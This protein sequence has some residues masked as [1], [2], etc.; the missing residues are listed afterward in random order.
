MDASTTT[1]R[2]RGVA[3]SDGGVDRDVID[4]DGTARG[5]G[6]PGADGDGGPQAVNAVHWISRRD[7]LRRQNGS[8]PAAPPADGIRLRRRRRVFAPFTALPSLA[9]EPFTLRP[10]HRRRPKS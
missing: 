8:K 5:N 9:R 4:V 3:A 2:G 1:S 7:L 6:G 10:A